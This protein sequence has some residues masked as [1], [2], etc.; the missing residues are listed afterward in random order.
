MVRLSMPL[1]GLLLVVLVTAHPQAGA[2]AVDCPEECDVGLRP[3]C[4]NNNVVYLNECSLSQAS[5]RNAS[6]AKLHDGPCVSGQ[7]GGRGS[8]SS[9]PENCQKIYTP[10]CG[11]DGNTYNNKCIL[12]AASCRSVKE[13][14]P[15]ITVFQE[16]PCETREECRLD[17]SSTYSPVCGSNGVTYG[18][19]CWLR[20]A[21]CLNPN[22]TQKSTGIC[23]RQTSKPS[24][25]PS[26]SS[27]SSC[28]ERCTKIYQP[29]CGTNSRTYN[30]KCILDAAS[31]RSTRNGQGSIRVAKDGVCEEDEGCHKNCDILYQPVC[32]SDGV[33]YDNRCLFDIAKCFNNRITV[34]YEGI[35]A[36][37][38]VSTIT[39]EGK[40]S[41]PQGKLA[42]VV[43]GPYC[44]DVCFLGFQPVCGSDGLVYSN[45]C[46]LNVARCRNLA[47]SKRN[48]GVCSKDCSIQ[49]Y[50]D[51]E[52]VC[53][54]DGIT[55][56]N[57]CFLVAARCKDSTI[58][59]LYYGQC[60]VTEDPV[61]TQACPKHG[62]PVC[63]SDGRTY[64]SLCQ[65]KKTACNNKG[66]LSLYKGPCLEHQ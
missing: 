32:G 52:A 40:R 51:D 46:K 14:K 19:E 22:I 31:C 12:D 41:D 26:S 6:I 49:C 1:A 11:S 3:V 8:S 5:C 42:A 65:L 36:E 45:E 20:L 13:G 63:G 2:E 56:E 59:R 28:D 38:A 60:V 18:N 43:S 37:V 17:C 30:N 4:G 39:S 58:R 55:Y 27:S 66:L 50:R 61:C 24:A 9:C 7:S 47:L 54:S 57:D 25:S 35:C 16:G 10:L 44:P 48:D 53:G 34:E 33:T 29:V 64:S 62:D 15:A 21:R 23:N